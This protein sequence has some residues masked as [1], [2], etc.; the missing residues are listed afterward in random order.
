M[1]TGEIF[2][3]ITNR[4]AKKSSSRNRCGYWQGSKAVEKFADY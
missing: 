2:A 1:S 3:D 4:C